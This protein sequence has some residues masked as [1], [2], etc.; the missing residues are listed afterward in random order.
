M[1]MT[2]DVQKSF[3]GWKRVPD[4]CLPN[5][6]QNGEECKRETSRSRSHQTRASELPIGKA[7][8]NRKD[9]QISVDSPQNLRGQREKGHKNQ[10]IVWRTSPHKMLFE[11]GYSTI[12]WYIHL[13]AF[14]MVMAR[15][16]SKVHSKVP[17]IKRNR[18]FCDSSVM[19]TF[20]KHHTKLGQPDHILGPW[21]SSFH[22][23]S[24][25]MALQ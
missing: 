4:N 5:K 16:C 10:D 12:N 20:R 11:T 14:R 23:A 9:N 24:Q 13:F 3:P 15:S 21:F 7:G 22:R 25:L 1:H 18:R 8:Q 2:D 6:T 19:T 17:M